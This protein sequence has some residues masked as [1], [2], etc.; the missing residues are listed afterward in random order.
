[1]APGAALLIEP[2]FS[3]APNRIYALGRKSAA[4][5][6]REDV[7]KLAIRRSKLAEQSQTLPLQLM[8]IAIVGMLGT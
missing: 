8:G 4:A 6:F 1:M 7:P 3:G 2:S 5:T